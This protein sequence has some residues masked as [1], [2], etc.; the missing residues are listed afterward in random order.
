[1]YSGRQR[2]GFV[3]GGVVALLNIPGSFIPSGDS[4][5]A[6]PPVAVLVLGAVLGLVAAGLLLQGWR[7]GK[8]GPVR[9]AVV[10]LALNVL[11]TLPAFFVEGVP[12]WVRLV[13]A[14]YVL[15]TVVAVVLLFSP[16]PVS[17]SA[18][19]ATR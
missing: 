7:S 4:D 11:T 3:L 8:R 19:P 1:M 2:A 6:G 14:L 5:S 10:L 9:A 12:A 13:A 15:A 18:A 17:S 16:S